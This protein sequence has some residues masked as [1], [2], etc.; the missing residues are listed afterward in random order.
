MVSPRLL[1]GLAA[2]ALACAGPACARLPAWLGGEGGAPRVLLIG[3]DGLD[4]DLVQRLGAEGKLPNLARLVREGA[5]GRLRSGEPILSPLVWTTIATGRRPQ[6]HGILDFVEVDPSGQVMPITSSRRQ[7]AAL[8]N[9]LG[10][11]GVASGF[12]GWYASYPAE[13]VTG[14]VVSDRLAFHQVKSARAEAG[15]TY[16]EALAA[17]LRRRVGEP[18]PELANT[19]ARFLADPGAVL[20]PDG[21]KRLGELA[22]SHATSEFYRRILPDLQS[23]TPVGV[24][25]V[26]FELVDACG[27]LFMEDAPPRRGRIDEQD[28]RAFAGTVERCYQYQDEVVGD[29]LGLAGPSTVTVICSDHGFKHGEQRP[30]TSGRADT[31]LAPLWHRLYGT[32]I[33]HGRGVVRGS[34]IPRASVLDIAPTVLALAG[35]PLSRE[36]GGDPLRAAFVKGTFPSPVPKVAR[37]EPPSR[38]SDPVA[39]EGG[40]ERVEQLRALGYIGGT[41]GEIAHDDRG[42]TAAS[43]MNEGSSRSADGDLDGGLRAYEKAIALDPRNLHARVFAARI[44]VHRG[45]LEGARRLIDDALALDP[46]SAAAL[47]QRANWA[48]RAGR[49]D[50]AAASLD[51]VARMDE[52]LPTLH[53]LRARLAQA[54]DQPAAA[55]DA[56]ARAE[57]LTDSD[58]LLGEILIQRVQVM[59]ALGRLDEGETALRR[60]EV[61]TPIGML[62]PARG[63]LAL[64]RGDFAGAAA[65]LQDAARRFPD[66]SVIH[67]TLG[68]A[69]GAT[70]KYAEAEAA[71]RQAAARAQTD[72]EREG[73]WGDLSLLFQK[74]GRE[75][76][77]AAALDQ[78]LSALPRSAA[79]WGMAGAA[80]GRA[81][82]LDGAIAAYERSVRLR[83]TAL[84]CKTLAALVFE[85]RH[86]RGRAVSLWRQ[87]LA[88]DPGQPDVERFLIRFGGAPGR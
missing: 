44:H 43:F 61:V 85:Q 84:A 66:D 14:F 17:D 19:R 33:L 25:G 80:R 54:R 35:V 51:A 57:S 68:Q 5:V 27:H 64:A 45:N 3:I 56:L 23:R 50:V 6:D 75:A 83:P 47:L 20:T 31:G 13:P 8:W 36:L 21:E 87:S 42:R 10:D 1:F 9:V 67:R 62:A 22:R 34:T 15:A 53:L 37:Y 46:S 28:Y 59:V 81:G 58:A 82:D 76:D 29:L 16:P 65:A 4:P 39:R 48:I 7:A 55:L 86:D 49:L 74:Q 11:F 77:A 60:A 79:L 78:G 88:L 72:D 71:F 12:V 41:P 40:A 38:S 24:L 52:R 30:E 2:V 70:G 73:A 32:L 69:L 26:Y 18:A 63:E